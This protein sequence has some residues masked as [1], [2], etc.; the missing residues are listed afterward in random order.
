ML[1]LLFQQVLGLI[2]LGCGDYNRHDQFLH[3]YGG[4]QQWFLKA[5][6]L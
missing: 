2:L 1:L 4:V 5:L 6:G 3:I